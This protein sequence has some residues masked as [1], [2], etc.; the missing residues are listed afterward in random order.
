MVQ[1]QDSSFRIGTFC[2]PLPQAETSD[3]YTVVQASS[4]RTFR[5][6]IIIMQ[7]AANIVASNS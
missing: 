7:L 2:P 1:Q 5:F 3:D 4:E 6:N